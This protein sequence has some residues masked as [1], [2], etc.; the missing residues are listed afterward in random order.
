MKTVQQL[1]LDL[2]QFLDLEGGDLE[3]IE[4]AIHTIQQLQDRVD[5]LEREAQQIKVDNTWTADR[6]RLNEGVFR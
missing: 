1:L 3:V 4:R 5:V 2:N 6:I